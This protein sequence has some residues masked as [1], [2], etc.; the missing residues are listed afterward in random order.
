MSLLAL[1]QLRAGLWLAR[2][3]VERLERLERA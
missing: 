1:F 2:S 3:A